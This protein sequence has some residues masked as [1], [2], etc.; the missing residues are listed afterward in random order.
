MSAIHNFLRTVSCVVLHLRGGNVAQLRLAHHT[1][2][3]HVDDGQRLPRHHPRGVEVV[4]SSGW[5][6]IGNENRV[7][8]DYIVLITRSQL[9]RYAAAWRHTSL[10]RASFL[11]HRTASPPSPTPRLSKSTPASSQVPS[12]QSCSPPTGR[13]TPRR[14]SRGGNTSSATFV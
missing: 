12:S 13:C 6:S 8:D 11:C 7:R 10:A 9:D 4:L 2:L 5:K 1:A 3:V 14:S